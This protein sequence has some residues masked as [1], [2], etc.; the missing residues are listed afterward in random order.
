[1]HL[2]GRNSADKQSLR[3]TGT[4]RNSKMA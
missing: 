3:T 1:M 4:Q 2:S